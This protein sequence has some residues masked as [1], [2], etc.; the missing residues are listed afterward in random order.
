VAGFLFR[1]LEAAMVKTQDVWLQPGKRH[2]FSVA[3][4]AAVPSIVAWASDP[5]HHKPGGQ[6]RFFGT[7][8]PAQNAGTLGLAR[9]GECRQ[10][11]LCRV[12]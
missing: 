12:V 11:F 10:G 7:A 4:D 1:P 2:V 6:M 8:A 5:A 9:R 3:A